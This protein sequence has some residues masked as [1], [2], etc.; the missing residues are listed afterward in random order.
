MTTLTHN[1]LKA[2]ASSWE[3]EELTPKPRSECEIREYDIYNRD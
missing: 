1:A 2:L 3:N